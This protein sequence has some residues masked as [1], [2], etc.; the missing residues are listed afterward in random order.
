MIAQNLRL[1][2]LYHAKASNLTC[3]DKRRSYMQSRDMVYTVDVKAG[4]Q[5][6]TY[7]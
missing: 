7:I 1:D 4:T 2:E 3:S 6:Y 5:L